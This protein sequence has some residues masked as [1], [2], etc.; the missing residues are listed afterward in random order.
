MLMP[1]T[2][3]GSKKQ[4][5]PRIASLKNVLGAQSSGDSARRAGPPRLVTTPMPPVVMLQGLVLLEMPMR[6]M[7]G[8]YDEF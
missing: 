5:V 6:P 1:L 2:R 7:S 8:M 4:P 3:D